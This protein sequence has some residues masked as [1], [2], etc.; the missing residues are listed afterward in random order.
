MKK[1][2][3]FLFFAF[4]SENC[5]AQP[6]TTFNRR[7]FRQA[8]KGNYEKAI[9]LFTKAI[10]ED[11]FFAD[12]YYNRGLANSHLEKFDL[13]IPDFSKA[14]ELRPHFTFAY[15][16]RGHSNPEGTLIP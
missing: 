12:A 8:Q 15:N 3:P 9:Q 11:M 14:I 10:E 16:N 6:A 2:I 4:F 1:F 5:I 13:S 7:G